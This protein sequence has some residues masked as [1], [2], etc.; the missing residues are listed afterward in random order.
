MI[1][2]KN[3]KKKSQETFQNNNFITNISGVRYSSKVPSIT[4]ECPQTLNDKDIILKNKLSNMIYSKLCTSKEDLQNNSSKKFINNIRE[5]NINPSLAPSNESYEGYIRSDSDYLGCYKWKDSTNINFEVDKNSLSDINYGSFKKALDE[6]KGQNNLLYFSGEIDDSILELNSNAEEEDNPSAIYGQIDMDAYKELKNNRVPD[7]YCLGRSHLISGEVKNY[8]G[9]IGTVAI[10]KNGATLEDNDRPKLFLRNNKIDTSLPCSNDDITVNCVFEFK[11]QVLANFDFNQNCWC[12]DLTD[13]DNNIIENNQ[14]SFDTYMSEDNKY[15]SPSSENNKGRFVFIDTSGNN[16]HLIQDYNY[17][18]FIGTYNLEGNTPTNDKFT[19]HTSTTYDF[20]RTINADKNIL[21]TKNKHST[22]I[23][24]S[25]FY[26][27]TVNETTNNSNFKENDVIK[28]KNDTLVM[29]GM[30]YEW[31]Y[32]GMI[33]FFNAGIP[34][35]EKFGDGESSNYWDHYKRTHLK[36]Q[37]TIDKRCAGKLPNGMAKS[38]SFGD[39]EKLGVYRAGGGDWDHHECLCHDPK[40]HKF[41]EPFDCRHLECLNRTYLQNIKDNYNLDPKYVGVSQILSRKDLANFE[42][43]NDDEGYLEIKLNTNDSSATNSPPTASGNDAKVAYLDNPD[44]NNKYFFR[45]SNNLISK[46]TKQYMFYFKFSTNMNDKNIFHIDNQK[47]KKY[48]YSIRGNPIVS[49]CSNFRSIYDKNELKIDDED[50]VK[51]SS[52]VFLWSYMKNCNID[53]TREGTKDGLVYVMPKKISS[54]GFIPNGGKFS[55]GNIL[56]YNTKGELIKINKINRKKEEFKCDS[57]NVLINDMYNNIKLANHQENISETVFSFTVNPVEFIRRIKFPNSNGSR[58][59]IVSFGNFQARPKDDNSHEKV[60]LYLVGLDYA[61]CTSKN[62]CIEKYKNKRILLSPFLEMKSY[63]RYFMEGEQDNWSASMGNF[64]LNAHRYGNDRKSIDFELRPNPGELWDGEFP[65]DNRTLT[66][67]MPFKSPATQDDFYVIKLDQPNYVS[68]IVVECSIAD[69]IVNPNDVGNEG[70][71]FFEGTIRTQVEYNFEKT[72]MYLFDEIE[73][74]K[75]YPDGVFDSNIDLTTLNNVNKVEF[76]VGSV[77]E[78]NNYGEENSVIDFYN[79]GFLADPNDTAEGDTKSVAVI[80]EK[81]LQLNSDGTENDQYRIYLK[82]I[83]PDGEVKNSTE[84]PVSE[85][86]LDVSSNKNY[87]IKIG[88]MFFNHTALTMEK[89][90]IFGEK[91]FLDHASEASLSPSE[92]LS[93]CT[94]SL[95]NSIESILKNK[96]TTNKYT[97]IHNKIKEKKFA[98]TTNIF[99]IFN[100]TNTL[101]R[102][103]TGTDY[104]M[105]GKFL[106]YELN[107]TLG[108]ADLDNTDKEGTYT[109]LIDDYLYGS[110]YKP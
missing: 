85:D 105:K 22:V 41:N 92:S 33:E 53:A 65:D 38:K 51:K 23:N 76:K 69:V 104:E 106:K 79:V 27:D 100:S 18:H 95:C 63:S 57:D 71:Y 94:T 4:E 89:L 109:K 47:K 14:L 5:V 43:P 24:I 78:K 62:N 82:S 81:S 110:P 1:L 19:S 56:I 68:R 50:A 7:K 8:L 75:I 97:N 13:F 67:Y 29:R 61:H 20:F 70:D 54:I 55:I 60:D 99:K 25:K 84:I 37:F 72:D 2:I 73:T 45:S 40:N 36:S 39:M 44:L 46:L 35:D 30:N 28:L 80:V 9:G 66:T 87:N 12:D 90:M 96:K 11:N 49:L 74:E 59:A 48:K 42:G 31:P 91:F 21:F 98:K 17:L 6:N 32:L 101:G 26:Q 88:N 3:S 107:P 58:D 15:L 64:G 34:S 16:N 108:Y 83:G 77:G 102:T 52:Q 103:G 93:E 10:Y 86:Y